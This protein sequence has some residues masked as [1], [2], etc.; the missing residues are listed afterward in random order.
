MDKLNLLFTIPFAFL[1][2]INNLVA[3]EGQIFFFHPTISSTGW[4]AFDSNLRGEQGVYIIDVSGKNLTQISPDGK[5]ASH[6]A[7]SPDGKMLCYESKRDGNYEIYAYDLTTKIETRLTMSDSSDAVPQWISN[8]EIV[9][10]S[11]RNGTF[12][13]YKMKLGSKKEPVLLSKRLD[14]IIYPKWSKDGKRVLFSTLFDKD[15]ELC[16]ANSKFKKIQRITF[17]EGLDAWGDWSTKGDQVVF[18]SRRSGSNQIYHFDLERKKLTTI[19]TDTENSALPTF[20]PDD[21]AIVFMSRQ[22]GKP[23]TLYKYHL[24]KKKMEEIKV[25]SKK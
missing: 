6:P 17:S 7:W 16:V 3:Q 11:N 12:Q 2:G 20:L 18:T 19:T 24:E 13:L 4:I 23:T 22:N 9:F 15:I 5:T 1:I 21:S 14:K 25:E 10:E 8:K